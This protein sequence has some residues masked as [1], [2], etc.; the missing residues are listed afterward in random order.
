[1]AGL[2]DR[3]RATVLLQSLW[4]DQDALQ[5]SG[6]TISS[7]EHFASFFGANM[8]VE[9]FTVASVVHRASVG[10]GAGVRVVHLDTSGADDPL[11]VL[12]GYE[13]AAATGLTELDG[14]CHATLLLADEP[15][16]GVSQTAFGD[17]AALLPSRSAAAR[18][19][20]AAAASASVAIRGVAEYE[21]QFGS[22]QWA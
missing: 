19:R 14:L 9:Q 21:L 17:A 1:M 5:A 15:G 2:V 20:A 10:P 7:P 3:D 18:V 22:P 13:Q 12:T 4:V 6:R 11:A 8:A 16:R